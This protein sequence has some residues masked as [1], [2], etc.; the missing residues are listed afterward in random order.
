MLNYLKKTFAFP[1]S[2]RLLMDDA[3]IV[4]WAR[5]QPTGQ[6]GKPFLYSNS[7]IVSALILRL[8]YRLPYRLAATM[9]AD[10]LKTFEVDIR[11][12]DHATL[13]YRRH[14]VKE[15]LQSIEN[16]NND[17]IIIDAKRFDLTPK[18]D[19]PLDEQ[20]YHRATFQIDEPR[21]ELVVKYQR[22]FAAAIDT[23]ETVKK[24]TQAVQSRMENS[25][26]KGA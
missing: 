15:R 5:A 10:L 12:P 18:N 22:R 14:A 7:L 25:A 4:A 26:I 17:C 6:R 1:R 20:A 21:R 24:S 23:L 8:F 11:P 16:E 3:A 13:Y 2:P 19:L 9:F